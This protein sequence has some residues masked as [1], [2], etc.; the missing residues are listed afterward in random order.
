MPGEEGADLL[1]DMLAAL[2]LDRPMS[3]EARSWF[4]DGCLRA[5]RRG[6]SIDSGL[7]L[8]AAGRRN[9]QL[10]FM[11]RLRDRHLCQALELVGLA[12][13]AITWTRCVRL[14]P[15]VVQFMRHDWP[16]SKRLDRPPPEWPG[17]KRSLW[18]AASTGV[19]LPRSPHALRAAV[20]RT[21]GYSRNDASHII[22]LQIRP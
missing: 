13:D 14:A 10:R 11:E 7:G 18:R 19:D 22:E 4:L 3:I 1:A 2:L 6:E 8:A 12:G 15:L 17:Y 9:L 20:L 16:K 5:L 21:M